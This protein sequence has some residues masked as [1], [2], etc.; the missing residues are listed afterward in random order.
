VDCIDSNDCWDKF[1]TAINVG[2]SYFV[3]CKHISSSKRKSV[4]KHKR[5]KK[6]FYPKRIKKT[7]EAQSS[8]VEKI[9]KEEN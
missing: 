4:K 1:Y 8:Y 9:Q 7:A 5:V 2:I 6:V 3:P